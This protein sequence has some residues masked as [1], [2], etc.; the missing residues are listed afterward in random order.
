MLITENESEPEIAQKISKADS[1]EYLT[2]EKEKQ[3]KVPEVNKPLFV[4]KK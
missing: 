1:S 2:N 4:A 3:R